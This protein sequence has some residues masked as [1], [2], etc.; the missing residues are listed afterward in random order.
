MTNMIHKY[1]RKPV[2]LEAMKFEYTER[3]IYELQMFCGESL[4]TFS[5]VRSPN[6]LGEAE[7]GT[8]EDGV[9]LTVKHIATEGDYIVRG[10]DGEFWAVKPDIFE[11]TYEQVFTYSAET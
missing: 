11:Q 4:G 1:R 5:K 7:L 6:A 9:N 3:G 8:L 2:V 10:V